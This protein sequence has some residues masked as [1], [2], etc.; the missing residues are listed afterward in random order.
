LVTEISVGVEG[1]DERARDAKTTWQSRTGS[2]VKD[3]RS[4]ELRK[5]ARRCLAPT[6]ASAT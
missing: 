6:R 4:A 5:V 2:L 3:P 1:D